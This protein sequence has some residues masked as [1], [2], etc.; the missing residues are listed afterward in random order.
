MNAIAFDFPKE[1]ECG[2]RRHKAAL[3]LYLGSTG[4]FYSEVVGVLWICM[5]LAEMVYI[6]YIYAKARKCTYSHS[7]MASVG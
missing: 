4:L 5:G 6:W 1:R 7:Y 3:D 2:L